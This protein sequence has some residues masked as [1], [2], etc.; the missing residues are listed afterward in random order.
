MVKGSE[1]P[2]DVRETISTL[3]QQNKDRTWN[4]HHVVVDG[5]DSYFVTADDFDGQEQFMID[6]AGKDISKKVLF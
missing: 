1:I 5:R 4:V 6:T 3:K 2:A